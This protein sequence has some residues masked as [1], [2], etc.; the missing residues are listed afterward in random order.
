MVKDLS[1]DIPELMTRAE[2][3]LEAAR[4]LIDKEYYPEAVSCAR[5]LRYVLRSYGSSSQRRY[6]GI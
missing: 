1:Q 2:R 5:L 6:R 4:L 3:S